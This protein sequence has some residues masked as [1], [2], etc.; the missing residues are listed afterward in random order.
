MW[1]PLLEQFDYDGLKT[2]EKSAAGDQDASFVL[3]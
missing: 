2:E 1:G 3:E